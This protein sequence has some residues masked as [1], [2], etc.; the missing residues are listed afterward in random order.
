MN[1]NKAIIKGPNNLSGCEVNATDLRA[2]AGLVVAALIA[3]GETTINN[4]D[5][6]LRGY[7]HIVKKI[8]SIGGEISLL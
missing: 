3:S 6:I 5:Y 1:G 7:E 4:A 8:S 2:G